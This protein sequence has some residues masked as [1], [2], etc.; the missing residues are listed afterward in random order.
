MTISLRNKKGSNLHNAS[1]PGPVIPSAKGLK[2]VKIGH[3]HAYHEPGWPE[4]RFKLTFVVDKHS[5]PHI[6]YQ[7]FLLAAETSAE[8]FLTG[9]EGRVIFGAF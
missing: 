8:Y 1:F 4:E 2:W 5:P 6:G 7:E 9:G 3:A